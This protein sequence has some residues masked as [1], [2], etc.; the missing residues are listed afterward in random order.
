M[1]VSK[2]EDAALAEAD[3]EPG[4]EEAELAPP[5]PPG[6]ELLKLDV[7]EFAVGGGEMM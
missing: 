1:C 2:G 5:V 4:V 7:V 6:P 3:A